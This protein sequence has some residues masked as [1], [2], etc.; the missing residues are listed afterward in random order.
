MDAVLFDPA[1]SRQRV[2]ILAL[3]QYPLIEFAPGALEPLATRLLA[4]YRNDPDAGIHGA[5]EWTLRQW[6]LQ[7]KLKPIDDALRS[8][9]DR[10]DGT[11][12][13]RRCHPRCSGAIFD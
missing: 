4:L 12:P 11:D 5:A 10:G 6:K 8:V 13:G 9:N 3:G 2:L 1:T 7:E